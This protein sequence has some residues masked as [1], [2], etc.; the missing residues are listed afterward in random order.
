MRS[1]DL[2]LMEHIEWIERDRQVGLMSEWM[3]TRIEKNQINGYN[4]DQNIIYNLFII[5]AI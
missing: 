5:L 4:N 3:G 2:Y 1:S